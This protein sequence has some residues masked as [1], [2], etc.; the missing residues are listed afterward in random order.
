VEVKSIVIPFLVI[1][2]FAGSAVA[3]QCPDMQGRYIGP[4]DATSFNRKSLR[5]LEYWIIP[6]SS[7]RKSINIIKTF[8]SLV[9]TYPSRNKPSFTCYYTEQGEVNYCETPN[10]NRFPSSFAGTGGMNIPSKSGDIVSVVKQ[11]YDFLRKDTI[12]CRQR[13]VVS[14]RIS[15]LQQLVSYQ[16]MPY[17]LLTRRITPI[18]VENYGSLP[19]L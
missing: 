13:Q 5:K 2:G 19:V 15:Y 4:N 14:Y 11:E 17:L 1:L 16:D 18:E 8:D 7:P 12:A 3:G 9:A 10:G 6:I